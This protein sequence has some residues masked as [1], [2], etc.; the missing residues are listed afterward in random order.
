MSLIFFWAF[1][2]FMAIG[3]PIVFAL[4]LAPLVGFTLAEK[5]I[6]L[7]MI[8]QRTFAG[9]NQFPLL[10]IPFF[11]L[12]G[13]LMNRSGITLSLV[14]FAN[15]LVGHLRGG[16][17]HVNIV[18]SMLFA[19]ISGS[20]VAD[21]SGVGSIMIPAMERDGYS[22]KFAAA[23]TAASSV[24]G[25]IIPPSIIMVV[26]AFMMNVSVAG[27]F[28][29]GVVPGLL[30]GVSLMIVTAII[31]RHRNYPKAERRAPVREVVS[32]ARG[33]ALPLLTPVIILGGIIGGVFTPTEAASVAA[34]YALILSVFV[35][36]TLKPSELPQIFLHSAISS[37]AILLVVGTATAFAWIATLSQVPIQLSTL[38][39]SISEDPLLLLFLVNVLLL[40]V[41]MFLDAGPA[42]LILGP[43]LA[44]TMVKL[45]VDP[46]H[47]AIIMCVN[48]TVGLATPPMGLILF[49]A[50]SLTKLRIEVIALEMLPFLAVE[51]GII[52]LITYVPAISMTLP[53]LLGFA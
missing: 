26:Y 7:K 11:I 15:A 31:S 6:F 2:L 42:I 49:V 43:I 16:L 20:A 48:L 4:G 3:V 47:F 14:N 1:L 41:G 28:A 44:P 19:G 9:I 34:A 27:L 24:I 45:G 51:I 38:L 39:F 21:T 32:A 46:L 5:Q 13:E 12:A 37:G 33:A 52:L 36:K 53:R 30:V 22:R 17:A 40:F 8:V 29:A 23:V 25:P 10:A 35:L 18:T 50:S